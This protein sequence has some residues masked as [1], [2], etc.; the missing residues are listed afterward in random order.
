M[1]VLIGSA[2]MDVKDGYDCLKIMKSNEGQF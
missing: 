2:L 1:E